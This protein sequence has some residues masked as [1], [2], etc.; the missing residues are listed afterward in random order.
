VK[1]IIAVILT[2][3]FLAVTP[4]QAND[5]YLPAQA[6]NPDLPAQAANPD[7]PAQAARPGHNVVMTLS[8]GGGI[9]CCIA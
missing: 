3:S 5:R 4:A 9:W 2:V 7:L 1:K 6:A 8:T